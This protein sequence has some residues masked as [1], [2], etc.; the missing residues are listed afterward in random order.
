MLRKLFPILFLLI[1]FFVNSQE[2]IFERPANLLSLPSNECYNIIQDKEGYIW[3]S[4]DA[5]LC[6]Y[7]GN[8]LKI[9]SKED[10]LPEESCYGSACNSKGDLYLITSENRLI[11]TINDKIY[12]LPFSKAFIEELKRDNMYPTD[13]SI[14]EDSLLIINTQANTYR[15]NLEKN[16]FIETSKDLRSEH[17]RIEANESRIFYS[18]KK[19]ALFEKM[20]SLIPILIKFND[21]KSF[22]LLI[23]DSTKVKGGRQRMKCDK[24]NK[25]NVYISMGTTLLKINSSGSYSVHILKD[26][27]LDLLVDK[28]NNLWIGQR[29]LG[30][31][32]YENGVIDESRKK[33]ALNDIS[34]TQIIE[35]ND[36][37]I[38]CSTLE[39]GVFC[40]YNSSVTKISQAAGY[41]T[42]SNLFKT[43]GS[44]LFFN[45]QHSSIIKT[46]GIKTSE[47]ILPSA[48]KPKVSDILKINNS[49]YITTNYGVFKA[50]TN[51]KSTLS[52][53]RKNS[54]S[55]YYGNQLTYC[56]GR[57]FG[58]NYGSLFEIIDLTALDRIFYLGAKPRSIF[59]HSNKLYIAAEEGIYLIDQNNFTYKIIAQIKNLKKG[60]INEAGAIVVLCK[61][62]GIWIISENK[63]VNCKFPEIANLK[64]NDF[65]LNS[66]NEVWLATNK[67]LIKM[68]IE[69]PKSYTI[70]DA[71]YGLPERN[72]KKIECINSDLFVGS[73]E[74]IFHLRNGWIRN[75]Q[76][77]GKLKLKQINLN[78]K[79]V[80][81]NELK[82]L[83][84]DQNNITIQVENLNFSKNPEGKKIY[85][86]LELEG[87]SKNLNYTIENEIFL[88]NLSPGEYKLNIFTNTDP[89]S[90]D[91]KVLSFNFQI[92]KPFWFQWWFLFL[93]TL[94]IA[95]V[96]FLLVKKYIKRIREKDQK[97][98]ELMNLIS[99]Y[100]MASIRAQMN[101]HFIF[102]C[103]NS[104]QRYI[105]TNDS[106]TAY[107]YLTKFSKLIR[108]V[109]NYSEEDFISL[110]QELEIVGLYVEME[111]LRFENVFTYEVNIDENIDGEKLTMPPM[112]LQPYIENS[113]WH[114][115]MHLD[116]SINGKILISISAKENTLV[117]T[118]EDNGIGREESKKLASR[119]HKSKAISLNE[120]R[121]QAINTINQSIKGTIVIE[122]VIDTDSHV[123]GTRV[124]II[125][126]QQNE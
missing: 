32:F 15:I 35:T 13:F 121:I 96:I 41:L 31:S 84:Y 103:I 105:I 51:C 87:I 1:H 91:Y 53:R 98:A 36:G 37:N 45:S 18:K 75:L 20:P 6:K 24:D 14:I 71:K 22:T 66:T 47:F 26:D 42:G 88:S 65:S 64:I 85:Y 95:G 120:K 70:Y 93:V 12:E 79:P 124:K 60:K 100:Q 112:M 83:S 76:N 113:I 72:F 109:L 123:K 54:P 44:N 57:I 25:G 30:I 19:F 4:T 80:S 17:L 106:K 77:L 58:I 78:N 67:G 48:D 81:S 74:E 52:I 115:I 118:V 68:S 3:F 23:P 61:Y 114:G 33:Y 40:C 8:K 82:D 69:N 28:K 39:K 101:P 49:L 104:I 111:Q 110:N 92:N 62:E 46:N 11:K 122:D 94:M 59:S 10:G 38:W 63:V 56:N 34:V 119:Q 86:Q 21:S 73:E 125:I 50:D 102:N 5:G 117:V 27:I 9:F 107:G 89:N 43:D 29:N 99:S 126:P 16:T 2:L 7:N 108:M 90:T 97:D 116:K 55:H